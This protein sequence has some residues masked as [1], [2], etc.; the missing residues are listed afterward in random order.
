MRRPTRLLA[1]AAVLALTFWSAHEIAPDH[2]HDLAAYAKAAQYAVSLAG[3]EVAEIRS[4]DCY[5]QV[6][7]ID[8]NATDVVCGSAW[9]PTP[10][11][12]T[13]TP[14][15]PPTPTPAATAV[16]EPD[17]EGVALCADHDR[18]TWHPLVKRNAA[19][20]ITCTYGHEH[21]EDPNAVNDIF[22][23]VG[24]W[25]GSVD[26]ISY[27]WHTV[28]ATTG[29]AENTAKHE[30][31]KFYVGRDLPCQPTNPGEGCVLAYRVEVHARG[32]ISDQTT[33][34][35]S[36]SL[37]ALVR[38]NGVQG[39]IRHGG[40]IDTGYLSL[41]VDDG[42]S[43]VCP[44]IAS[45]PP[46]FNCDSGSTREASSFNP[47]AP[48]VAHDSFI[49]TWYTTHTLTSVGV[50][51]EEWGP[52]DYY[53]PTTQLFHARPGANNSSGQVSLWIDGGSGYIR[54]WAD[55]SGFISRNAYTTAAGVPSTTCTAPG[56]ACVPLQLQSIPIKTT[57]YTGLIVPMREFEVLSPVTGKSLIRFPN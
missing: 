36:Y 18:L 43:K 46:T 29:V 53:N 9:T 1:T 14:P 39:M 22:G 16:P 32:D 38:Y 50:R 5:Q 49:T 25:Y 52:I 28:N 20:A 11:P 37:E 19:G 54:P 34:F 12:P 13:A 26:Q 6:K 2:P 4:S 23:P 44:P 47:P 3:G 51:L 30:G 40:H 45:N 7:V 17:V 56:L 48:H 27:P 21:R 41:I 57:Q 24:A 10:R 55:A 31:Y 15:P 33:R 8:R 35:H 42:N